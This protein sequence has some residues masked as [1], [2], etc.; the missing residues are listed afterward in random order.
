LATPH[1]GARPP[2]QAISLRFR[3]RLSGRCV[4]WPRAPIE[5]I[6]PPSRD[7]Q[8]LWSFLTL[9]CR[10]GGS[11]SVPQSP[12]RRLSKIAHSAFHAS[13]SSRASWRASAFVFSF[14]QR[15]GRK[16]GICGLMDREHPDHICFVRQGEC[17]ARTI[18]A[19][20]AIPERRAYDCNACGI[21]F[22]SWRAKSKTT[23]INGPRGRFVL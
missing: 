10:V 23:E 21:V 22:G 20:R 9:L 7:I 8:W 1:L 6:L 4:L 14:D 16:I 2:L 12:A 5:S 17:L 13:N 3:D 15:T 11:A 19:S 18:P